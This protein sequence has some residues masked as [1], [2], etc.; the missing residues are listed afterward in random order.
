M[1][2]YCP[3]NGLTYTSLTT[4]EAMARVTAFGSQT[5]GEVSGAVHSAGGTIFYGPYTTGLLLRPAVGEEFI[6]VKGASARLTSDS[7]LY[8]PSG[9]ET[10]VTVEF[11]DLELSSSTTTTSDLIHS[12]FGANF[13]L[14]INRCGIFNT[15]TPASFRRG[16]YMLQ[17]GTAYQLCT[18][19]NSIIV[20]AE[21][22]VYYSTSNQANGLISFENNTVI[23]NNSSASTCYF[24]G[25]QNVKNILALGIST[26]DFTIGT[27]PTYYNYLASGDTTASSVTNK[28]T[29][30]NVNSVLTNVAGGDYTISPLSAM[31]GAGESGGNIGAFVAPV[32][33]TPPYKLGV[34]SAGQGYR[35]YG[36]INTANVTYELDFESNPSP[37]GANG[38]I[39]DGRSGASTAYLLINSSGKVQFD[40]GAI[41][42]ID[43]NGVPQSWISS[44][45]SYVG[46][47]LDTISGK[48]LTI[49]LAGSTLGSGYDGSFF[50]GSRYT[51]VDSCLMQLSEVRTYASGVLT[52]KYTLND[53]TSTVIRDSK[54]VYPNG[55]YIGYID[56]TIWSVIGGGGGATVYEV[57]AMFNSINSILSGKV[58]LAQA[59]ADI[60][61]VYTLVNTGNANFNTVSEYTTNATL[62]CL[63][64]VVVE[65]S[66]VFST[67]SDMGNN[68]ASDVFSITDFN[69]ILNS[70][71]LTNI[72][73][74][75]N[76]V[77]STTA[78]M[79]TNTT[80]S[81]GG[82]CL[83]NVS[84]GFS[85]DKECTLGSYAVFNVAN[86]FATYSGLTSISVIASILSSYADSAEG[87]VLANA[88]TISTLNSIANSLGIANAFS[89][90]MPDI[91]S[92]VVALGG[93]TNT[94]TCSFSVVSS[95]NS[96]SSI[97]VESIADY[98]TSLNLM[99]ATVSNIEASVSY[100]NIASVISSNLAILN[101]Q[102]SFGI[103]SDLSVTRTLTTSAGAT[104]SVTC[105]YT[106]SGLQYTST[107][108]TTPDSRMIRVLS[109]GRIVQILPQ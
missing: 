52:S 73:R 9:S 7:T 105:G 20:G 72:D 88:N 81:V 11:R 86:D 83:G 104:I 85:V 23:S 59:S 71:S 68:R 37:V 31:V 15:S 29:G 22:G 19:K 47:G 60:S 98:S 96:S 57:A 10:Q 26:T 16:V 67:A 75:A 34:L 95:T 103:S 70:F 42:S 56:D 21:A 49:H 80:S 1:A 41:S 40:S 13:N 51:N 8:K 100:T 108:V 35:L 109:E 92:G 64:G 14:T 74:Q 27:T 24:N 32:Y 84:S 89:S 106:T 97:S 48:T 66:T 78:T 2:I 3:N 17:G 76:V 43:I 28:L 30:I 63:G 90:I 50:I 93:Q 4:F 99:C 69:S 6:G 36:P 38:Y 62:A 102:S 25:I 101:A 46:S 55:S 65:A 33:G 5:I 87:S 77:G 54:S 61:S 82:N 94:S 44:S 58:C 91:S 12:N 45:T 39:F 53:G 79:L 107:E 18:I